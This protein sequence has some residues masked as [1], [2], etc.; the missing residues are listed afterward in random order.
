[1]TERDRTSE[2]TQQLD[3]PPGAEEERGVKEIL[4][5]LRPQLQELV[6]LHGEMARTELEPVAKRAGRAVGL[7]VAGA[8]FLF[9][10]LIFFFLAGM[11]TMQA[12]G[13]PPWA[14]AGINAVILLIIAGVLAGAG[15]AGLRGLDPK[16]QRT[17]RSVQRSIEWFKEQFGR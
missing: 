12:A 6:R 17:I 1:M 8:V 7:L 15:A 13:F 3:R 10:F 4:K 16:P 5:E 2:I 9:L 11:Y 14:A